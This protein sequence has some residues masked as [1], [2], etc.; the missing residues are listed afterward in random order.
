M[1]KL[2]ALMLLLSAC[3]TKVNTTVDPALVSYVQDFEMKMGVPANNTDVVFKPTSYPTIGVC[4]RGGEKNKVEIDPVQWTKMDGYGKE[5]LIYHELG[6]CVLGLSH[7]D[8]TFEMDGWNLPGSIMNTFWFGNAW[9]YVKYNE[10]YKQA[11]KNNTL[12]K[13]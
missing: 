12:V 9:Y 4:Y 3:G 7:N 5:Q 10:K 13:E 8:G 2:I 6:H 1:K 11:L